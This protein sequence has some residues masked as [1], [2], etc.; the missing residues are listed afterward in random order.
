MPLTVEPV[1]ILLVED[2]IADVEMTREM[3]EDSKI[4]NELHVVGDG[5]SAIA[6]LRGEGAYAGRQRPDLVLLDLN[7]PGKSGREVL[8]EVKADGDLRTIPVIVMTTSSSD[9]DILAAYRAYVNCYIRKP[10]DLNE[11]V[12][13][14][15]TIE[16]F[17]LSIVRLPPQ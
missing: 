12:R 6:F 7:L 17:W 3:L 4:A 10:L 14:V 1:Q 9:A 8:V 11:F 5:D 16:D 13:V 2:N 15:Q